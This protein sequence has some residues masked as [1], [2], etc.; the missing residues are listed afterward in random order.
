M[1]RPQI[2]PGQHKV[3]LSAVVIFFT[4]A[5][6][7]FVAAFATSAAAQT[8][9]TAPSWLRYPVIS[10]DGQTIVFAYKGDIYRVPASGG[11]AI[12]LTTHEAHDYMPVWSH[13]SRMIAF[14][15]DRFGNFDIYVMPASGGQARRLTFH[16]ASE[17][18]Y[19]FTPDDKAILFGAARLDTAANRQF[20]TGSQP[21]LYRV[22]ADGGRAVQV[23]ATPAEDARYS[24]DGRFLIYHDKKGGENEW[25]KH[26][27][28]AITR[29][30]WVYDT[31]NKT[32]HIITKFAGEDRSPVFT[33]DEKG[34]YYLTEESGSFNVH[35]LETGGGA[36][37]QITKFKTH[38]VRFLSLADDG[39]LCFGYDGAIYTQREGAEPKPV[40]ITL[41]ADLRS[42][43]EIVVPISGG[44]REFAVSPSGKEIAVV[45]RGGIFATSV[46]GGVTKRVTS[47]FGQESA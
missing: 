7:I 35:R 6:F 13:D 4:F 27:T 32:H 26:H 5:A 15:S 44:A 46:D 18:P 12:P 34:F 14:A 24:R 47:S 8:P 31:Q 1:N 11:A 45:A 43:N 16:S 22:P 20:P 10:P 17:L 36:S 2:P 23:L 29:D 41:A 28:S 3:S 21:E 9:Q 40:A 30:I 33:L 42:N 38:P 37:T 25:R 19:S 39:T